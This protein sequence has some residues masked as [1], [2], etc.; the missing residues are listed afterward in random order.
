MN[1]YKKYKYLSKW[2]RLIKCSSLKVFFKFGLKW[3]E[4]KLFLRGYEYDTRYKNLE[5]YGI[6]PSYLVIRFLSIRK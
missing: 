4:E 3:R 1:Y 5:G 6:L 2:V